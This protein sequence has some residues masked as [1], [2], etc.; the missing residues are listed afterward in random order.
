MSPSAC[1]LVPARAVEL[2]L[3]NGRNHAAPALVEHR[4]GHWT[5]SLAAGARAMERIKDGDAAVWFLWA[6]ADWQKGDRNEALR[7]YD[8]TVAR[9]EARKPLD[10]VVRVYWT[11]AAGLLGQPGPQDP[12]RESAVAP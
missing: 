8:E 7:W 4:L 5:E 10:P 3:T 12:A 9:V 11:E 6:L 1:E 2:E